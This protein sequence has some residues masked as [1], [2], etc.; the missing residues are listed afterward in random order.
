MT[1]LAQV[2]AGGV[3]AAMVLAGCSEDTDPGPTAGPA[4]TATV[5][6]P[7]LTPSQSPTTPAWQSKYTDD[8]LAIYED[9]LARQLEYFE[10]K[11]AIYKAGK[12][13]PEAR[14]VF[15]E[16][17]LLWPGLVAEL[18]E[19]YDQRGLRIVRPPTPLS[20]RMVSINMNE[21][22]TG[23]LLMSQC[24]DY[25]DILVT[26]NGEELS[27]TKPD[28][29][30]TALT[31]NMSKPEGRDWMLATTELKDKQSCAG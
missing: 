17:S 30:I 26:Q 20:T 29:L 3:A 22:G 12:D 18:A 2:L 1:R 5:T 23:S 19:S 13:T 15:R 16:Y 25:S 14:E 6:S 28:H 24:T 9:A 7:S 10:K 8:E 4:P 11:N 27:G 31:I 21:D